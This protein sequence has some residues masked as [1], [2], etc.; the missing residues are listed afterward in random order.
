MGFDK[1]KNIKDETLR[2]NELYNYLDE[3]SRFQT[4]AASIEFLTTIHFINK[5]LKHKDKIIDVGAGTGSYSLYFA[6]KGYNI[7]AVELADRNVEIFKS[8]IKSN[9]NIDLI[10][11][12]ALD[13]S[14]FKDKKF[15]HAFLMGPM[16]HLENKKDKLKS[17]NEIKKIIANEGYIYISF[18]NNDMVLL[19]EQSYDPSFILSNKY[20]RNSFKLDNFPFIF[21]TFDEMKSLIIKSGLSIE[22]IV[23]QDG[24]AEILEE[25]INKYNDEEFKAYLDIHIH[26]STKKEMLGHSNHILFICR[27][28]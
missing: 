3:D 11:G 17:I 5:R 28:K 16:Y 2:V 26:L 10:Q 19:S 24:L 12:N 7:S 15:D 14:Y 27:L 18:I 20:D 8:K 13:L 4:K 6:D 9:M 22:S 25:T 23:A 1:I 21:H